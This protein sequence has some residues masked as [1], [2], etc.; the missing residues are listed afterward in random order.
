MTIHLYSFAQEGKEGKGEINLLESKRDKLNNNRDDS[1]FSN[2]V[3]LLPIKLISGWIN[4]NVS[5]VVF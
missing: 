2:H 1:R 5:F 4:F 3:Q